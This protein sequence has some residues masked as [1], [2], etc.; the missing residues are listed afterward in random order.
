MNT[1]NITVNS[2]SSIRIGG[3]AAVVYFDPFQVKDAVHDADLILITHEHFDHFDPDSIRKIMKEST[4][5]MSPAGMTEMVKEIA[6]DRQIIGVSPNERIEG[7]P[8]PDSLPLTVETVRAY[9]PFKPF[10]PKKNQWVGYIL[11]MDGIRYYFAGDTDANEELK[12]ITCD[13]ALVPIGGKFTMTAGEAAGLVNAMRPKT[14]I[15]VH[16]GGVVGTKYDEEIFR[17]AVSG[18]IEVVLKLS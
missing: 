15:P 4:V 1:D 16:Y 18:S 17:N 13:I 8:L 11:T 5:F 10:H 9:N 14:A 12:G 6:G 7:A 2:Q 3:S